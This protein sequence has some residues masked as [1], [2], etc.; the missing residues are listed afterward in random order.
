MSPVLSIEAV[1]PITIIVLEKLLYVE[2]LIFARSCQSVKINENRSRATV[3][4][5]FSD[6]NKHITCILAY[7]EPLEMR[8]Y[9]CNA[10]QCAR[11]P[12]DVSSGY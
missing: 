11:L 9:L 3:K 1:E 4:A 8:Q 6:T 7:N 5:T 12:V 10:M 2:F